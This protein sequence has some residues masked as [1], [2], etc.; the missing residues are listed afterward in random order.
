MQSSFVGV[1]QPLKS[2][3]DWFPNATLKLPA[4]AGDGKTIEA[5]FPDQS[6]ILNLKLLHRDEVENRMYFDAIT[7]NTTSF[8]RGQLATFAASLV[9]GLKAQAV[10]VSD[11]GNTLEAWWD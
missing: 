4:P 2:W 1:V 5:L 9:K 11:D 8:S 3:R 7:F 6:I 10:T